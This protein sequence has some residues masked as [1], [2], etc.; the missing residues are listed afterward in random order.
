MSSL[1]R[2]VQRKPAVKRFANSAYVYGLTLLQVLLDLSPWFIRN[3]VWRLLLHKCGRRVFFDH[4]I[5]FKFPWLVSIGSDVSINRGVEFYCSIFDGTRI[6]IGDGVCI[7]PNVR[8]HSAGHDPDHPEFMDN[9][10]DIVVEDGAWIGAGTIVLQGV[11][12][13]RGA[14]IAAGSVVT[15]DIPANCIAGGTPARVFRQRRDPD[16]VG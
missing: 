1:L 11:R 2:V 7:A 13:G 9:G 15:R 3:G 6:V 5:Y 14:V 12:I 4:R 8:F 10:A 16:G